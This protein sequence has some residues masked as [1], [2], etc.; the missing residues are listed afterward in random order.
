MEVSN[1]S[2]QAQLVEAASNAQSKAPQP[3]APARAEPTEKKSDAPSG[4][5]L[6]GKQ[7]ADSAKRAAANQEMVEKTSKMPKAEEVVAA[8]I[9][10]NKWL[11]NRQVQVNHDEAAGKDV[12]SLVEKDS[13]KVIMQ[14]PAE[15]VLNISRRINQMIEVQMQQGIGR[16][17]A[18]AVAGALVQK[19]A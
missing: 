11:N 17:Q 4:A 16:Q 13:G 2:S 18:G 9:E 3:E 7:R 19:Q 1:V 8:M 6:A 12:Y 14:F 10:L 5:E 15:E